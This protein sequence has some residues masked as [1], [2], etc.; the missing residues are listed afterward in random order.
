MKTIHLYQ[1]LKEKDQIEGDKILSIPLKIR[2]LPTNNKI[3]KYIDNYEKDKN[4]NYKKD[5]DCFFTIRNSKLKKKK[6]FKYNK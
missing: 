4:I 3:N 2:G 6:Y 1:L 5:I